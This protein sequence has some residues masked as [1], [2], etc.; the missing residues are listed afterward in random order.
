[1]KQFTHKK[2]CV[3]LDPVLLFVVHVGAVLLKKVFIWALP[4]FDN[5]VSE[6]RGLN[7]YD[8]PSCSIHSIFDHMVNTKTISELE[9]GNVSS[10][11]FLQ[12]PSVMKEHCLKDATSQSLIN[13]SLSGRPVKIT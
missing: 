13:Y 9:T 2:A 11:P 1:M 4:F 6:V 8:F 3:E 7:A 12:V 5:S 10:C